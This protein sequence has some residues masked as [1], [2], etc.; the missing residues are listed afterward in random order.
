MTDSQLSFIIFLARNRLLAGRII[1]YS[2]VHGELSTSQKEAIITLIEKKD[3]DRQLIKNWRLISLVNID[4]KIGY[5][6]E[7]RKGPAM[8][9]PP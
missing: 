4:V 8:F 7:I 1:N 6:K 9:S 2:Y 5:C 3:R